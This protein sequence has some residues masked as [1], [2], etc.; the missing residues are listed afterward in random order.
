M[1]LEISWQSVENEG[2]GIYNEAHLADLR[3][4]CIEA[5]KKGE[6]VSINFLRNAPGWV[7][8]AANSE[9][10]FTAAFKH[11]QRRLKNCKAIANWVC[12]G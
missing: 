12:G 11:A 8:D 5:E 10:N 9:E 7:K 1:Q 4:A 2:P 6:T 3:K